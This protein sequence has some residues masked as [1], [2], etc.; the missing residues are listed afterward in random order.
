MPLPRRLVEYRDGDPCVRYDMVMRRAMARTFAVAAMSLPTAATPA[1]RRGPAIGEYDVS[2]LSAGSDGASA[3]PMTATQIPAGTDA[4]LGGYIKQKMLLRRQGEYQAHGGMAN[5]Y[6]RPLQVPYET[7]KFM[8]PLA[9]A[10]S[11]PMG[12]RTLSSWRSPRTAAWRPRTIA[13]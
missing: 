3:S 6:L 10:P 7:P 12:R 13:P 5:G 9:S 2:I 1:R 4:V 11:T 8:L